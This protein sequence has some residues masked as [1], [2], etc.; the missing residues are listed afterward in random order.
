MED[1][2]K[3]KTKIGL[4]WSFFSQFANYGMQ[5]IVGIVMAR[6]LSPSDFGITALPAVFMS[7]AS[8]FID[9]GFG[10]ALVRK[11]ELTDKDLST[12]FYYGI[13]VGVLC[14]ATLFFAS[15]WIA[16]FYNTPILKQ[17]TRVSALVFLWTPLY[18]PQNVILRRRLD[19]KTPARIAITSSALSGIVGITVAYLGFGVWALV[20]A[21]L[22]TSILTF[23]QTWSVVKWVPRSSGSKE[24]FRYLWGYGNKLIATNLI[25][26]LYAN[27]APFLLG[28]F[29]GTVDLGHYNR[30]KGFAALPSANV[31][32][33]IMSVTF[34][35]LSKMQDEITRLQYNYRKMIRVSAFVVFPMMM[36]LA[37]L[38]RPLIIILLTEKWE[39]CIYLLQI[40]C[41]VFMWAPIQK[42]NV[43]LLQVKGRTDLTLKLELI[44]K[45]IGALLFIF[46]LKISVVAFCYADCLMQM[47]ALLL[48]TYYTGKIIGVGYLRQMRDIL[49]TF[50]LSLAVFGIVLFLVSIIKSMWLSLFLGVIVG[51]GIY[52]GVSY[53]FKFE[54]LEE[55]KY[56]IKRNK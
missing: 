24:S 1:N 3:H 31:T 56:M 21:T 51:G 34:P 19:F 52:I 15:P 14:Y 39:P 25:D 55:I 45:P 35:V 53:F 50:I 49:P 33:V 32:G 28:K 9:G 8:V 54:E 5:F 46:S 23:F 27:I 37:A 7:V 47:I 12:S 36:L 20:I 29:G 22:T 4:Y 40:L 41:F 16:D 38:A 6:L 43:N 10:M 2:L 48:N 13:L 11:K 26:T 18:T 44:K 42:L 17:L 30:A